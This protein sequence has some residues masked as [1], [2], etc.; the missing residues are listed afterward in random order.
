MQ[1]EH[2]SLQVLKF[3]SARFRQTIMNIFNS[4]AIAEF[5]ITLPYK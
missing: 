3:S 5:F 4:T 1:I 2:K